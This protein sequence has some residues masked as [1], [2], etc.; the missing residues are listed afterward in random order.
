[1]NSKPILS[2]NMLNISQDKHI[3]IKNANIFAC[4]H[5]QSYRFCSNL[6]YHDYILVET[7]DLFRSFCYF[8][9]LRFS[10]MKLKVK[11]SQAKLS[12]ISNGWVTHI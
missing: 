5:V 11:D 10:L 6:H 7:I 3:F 12:Q 1:M 9:W 8:E 2:H 4:K